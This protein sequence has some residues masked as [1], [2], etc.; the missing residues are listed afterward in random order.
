[1]PPGYSRHYYDLYRL[2][3]SN[4]ATN[5]LADLPLLDAVVKF[6]T[7]F[8]RSPWANYEAAK[9]GSFRLLPT[10]KGNTELQADYRSMQA[11]IFY[12]PP[13]WETIITKLTEL[14]ATINAL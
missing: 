12:S 13:T 9:P 10:E 3:E 14:E 2:A 5:A 1:M 4:I 8:Y 11:M 6:K 7:R